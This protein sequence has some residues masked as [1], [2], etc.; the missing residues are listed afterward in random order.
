MCTRRFC[1]QGYWVVGWNSGE[2]LPQT[3]LVNGSHIKHRFERS[4]TG[5][6]NLRWWERSL[7]VRTSHK[8]FTS[9]RLINSVHFARIVIAGRSTHCVVLKKENWEL[10]QNS[11]RRFPVCSLHLY[12]TGGASKT[13]ILCCCMGINH[14]LMII[15]HYW[16]GQHLVLDL[17]LVPAASLLLLLKQT[18]CYMMFAL[19]ADRQHVHTHLPLDQ[20]VV[21]ASHLCLRL[22]RFVYGCL[23]AMSMCSW[24]F[25]VWLLIAV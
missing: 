15:H 8:A 2:A 7:Q 4:I 1:T 24:P 23:S 20:F 3:A 17:F 12:M 21:L 13:H 22:L 19:L 18:G 5:A 10:V 6:V 9:H 14:S 11:M 25:P 16:C